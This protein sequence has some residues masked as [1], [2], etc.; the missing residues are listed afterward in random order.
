[1]VRGF[2]AAASLTALVAACASMG[3]RVGGLPPSAAARGHEVA[4]RACAACHAVEAQGVSP[5]VK[6]PAFASQEMRHTASLQDRVADLTRR[7][8]YDM[9]PLKLSPDEVRDLVS[10]IA[11]LEG[12]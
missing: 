2:L 3:G 1:M 7:G 11:S 8:H 6:A 4:R 9:P 5:R 10:Y 12:R